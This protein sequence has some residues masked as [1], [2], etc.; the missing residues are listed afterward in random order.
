M[1]PILTICKRHKLYVIEDC[2][3]SFTGFEYIG[4][5][6]S[7][8]SMFSF[9]PI[10][11]VTAFGGALIRVKDPDIRAKMR[12]LHASYMIQARSEYLKK[13]LKYALVMIG[14]NVPLI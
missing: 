1:E 14:L 13:I 12:E 2:A 7:D 9:G 11:I 5:P 6:E 4:H 3:E 10:K 8:I